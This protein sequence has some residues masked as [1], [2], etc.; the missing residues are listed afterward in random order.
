MKL[1]IKNFNTF[2]LLISFVGLNLN[3][4]FAAENQVTTKSSTGIDTNT[5]LLLVV[6]LL[7]ICIISMSKALEYAVKHYI[8]KIR[9]IDSK[10][11]KNLLIVFCLTIPVYSAF[12]QDAV[13]TNTSTFSSYSVFTYFLIAIIFIE[14]LLIIFFATKIK[15]YIETGIESASSDVKSVSW[16]EEIWDKLNNFRP[17]SEESKLDTGHS[18]DGIRELNNITPP[19]FT[20]SFLGTIVFAIIYMWQYHVAK[21][22]PLAIEEF[23]NEMKV[24]EVAKLEMLK[25]E[26]NSIDETNVKVLGA[27]DIDAG[28]KLFQ[29]NCKPCHGEKAN[30][31]PGGV[32]PNLTD[33]NWIHGGEFVDIF[34]LIKYGFPEKGMQ[35][36]KDVLTPNQIAQVASYI[37]S[38][39]GTN[40]PGG[41]E[42]Q[43]EKYIPKTASK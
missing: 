10:G 23:E 4:L 27:A 38:V 41:K 5:I 34:K 36:W 2:S 7:L 20:F 29:T 16:I 28:H 24:A 32:G 31:M 30:S 14:V 15:S 42:P 37:E 35:S 26:G 8:H 43:G 33:E 17:L 6:L 11:L 13:S 3:N 21:N 19:W 40:I 1:K 12:A 22:A 18:Y 25:K 39:K 9:N